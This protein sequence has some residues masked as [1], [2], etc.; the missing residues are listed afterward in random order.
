LRGY[1]TCL[2]TFLPRCGG[3]MSARDF[4]G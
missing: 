1:D 3:K 2:H 4:S